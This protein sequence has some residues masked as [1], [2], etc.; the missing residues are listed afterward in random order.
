MS[1]ANGAVVE[2]SGSG[3]MAHLV[4]LALQGSGNYSVLWLRVSPEICMERVSKLTAE[5]PYPQF[6]VPVRLL[7]PELHARLE[8]EMTHAEIWPANRV[9][10]LDGSV[11]PAD[12]LTTALNCVKRTL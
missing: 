4:K 9:Q 1:S 8:R 2:F 3:Y 6:G 10:I 7:I 5:V 11:S 12:L